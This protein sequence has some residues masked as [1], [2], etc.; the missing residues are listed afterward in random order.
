MAY[1]KFNLV[2]FFI[3]FFNV[4][5]GPGNKLANDNQI[6]ILQMLWS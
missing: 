4:D 5:V 1:I 2:F 6:T 3:I